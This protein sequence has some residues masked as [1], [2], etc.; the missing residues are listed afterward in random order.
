MAK[1]PYQGPQLVHPSELISPVQDAP[2]GWTRLGEWLMVDV[3]VA[4]TI[5]RGTALFDI[6]QALSHRNAC[7]I[8][9]ATLVIDLLEARPADRRVL[10]DM[11]NWPRPND[12][13]DGDDGAS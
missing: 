8:I 3:R 5:P 13:K 9:G 4:K 1:T 12:D 7:G 2:M 6:C 11:T 10:L